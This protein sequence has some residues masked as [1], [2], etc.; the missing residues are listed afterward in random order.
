ML[1]VLGTAC[2]FFSDDMSDS[3]F[4]TILGVVLY[5][6]P[7][8]VWYLESLRP[9]VGRWLLV[10]TLLS[11]SLV[12]PMSTGN[13]VWASLWVLPV[14]LASVLIGSWAGALTTAIATGVVALWVI[15]GS[16]PAL[17]SVLSMGL[18]YSVLGLIA[19]VQQHIRWLATWSWEQYCTARALT[20]EA[21]DQRAD[22][23][24]ALESL[25]HANRQLALVNDRLAVARSV[26]EDAQRAKAA[27]VAQ[28]SHEFRTPLNLIIGLM[29]L[30]IETPGVYEQAIPPALLEDMEIVHHSSEHLASMIN[31]VLDLSQIEA[32]LLVLHREPVNLPEM[33]ER[34]LHIV[35]PLMDL[36]DLQLTVDFAPDL[37]PVPCDRTRILQVILNLLSNAAR[38]TDVGGVKIRV[39][40]EGSSVVTSVSDTGPGIAPENAARIFEPF[41]QAANAS[42]TSRE[43]SG[44]GLSISR[45]FVDLHGGTMWIESESGVGST[46][47]FALPATF[48]QSP[49]ESPA[50]WS[51]EQWTW[52]QRH[53]RPAVPDTRLDRRFVVCDPSGALH[54]LLARQATSVDLTS[55]TSLEQARA[56]LAQA[57]A[58]ALILNLPDP[59]DLRRAVSEATLTVPDVPI[60]GVAVSRSAEQA[61]AAGASDYMIKPFKRAQLEAAMRHAAGPHLNHVLVVDDDP[62]TL[63]L[64]KRMLHSTFP[65]LQ[66]TTA[67]SGID[68][69]AVLA[70]HTIDLVLLDMILPD[71]DGWQFLERKQRAERGGVVPVIVA[72]AQDPRTRPPVSPVLLAAMG[73][74]LSV[75][76]LWSCLRVVTAALMRPASAPYPEPE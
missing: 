18:A 71:M 5:L 57:P 26:A 37:P 49:T 54:A 22:L 64:L 68:G 2:F 76:Q 72:S 67:L 24:Q 62:H 32:G 8:V 21:L 34:A 14:S 17:P 15:G 25:A 50:R 16:A 63:R 41:V 52:T 12:L 75:T 39:W 36:K 45:Q 6:V 59:D 60:I 4:V 66:V 73:D 20:D 30:L 38:Y 33:V 31:D 11:I 29:D 1:V 27:F 70:E 43:G 48:L 55:T 3:R 53:T 9:L 42:G 69:L 51:S 35:R 61:L 13:W 44:L 74:G 56:E 23:K 65:Q 10:A 19:G 28:V 7:A 46:F 40:P 58:Q 47:Y